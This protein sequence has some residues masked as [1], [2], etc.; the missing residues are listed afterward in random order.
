MNRSIGFRFR[1]VATLAVLACLPQSVYAEPD[2]LRLLPPE[3]FGF[4]YVQNPSEISKELED[5]GIE[6]GV[7][8]PKLLDVARSVAGIEEGFDAGKELVLG[9]SSPAQP[10]QQPQPFALVPVSDYAT[11]VASFLPPEQ[12]DSSGIKQITMGGSQL[13]CAERSGYALLV[14]AGNG[15]LIDKLLSDAPRVNPNLDAL[16]DDMPDHDV[17]LVVLQP[18]VQ[19]ALDTVI[20]SIEQV[21]A[22]LEAI[23]EDVPEQLEA[24]R[25]FISLYLDCLRVFRSDTLLVG[26]GL[27]I[28]D[29]HNTL[30]VK[31]ILLKPDGRMSR[32]FAAKASADEKPLTKLVNQP[33]VLAAALSLPKEWAAS[34]AN[35]SLRMLELSSPLYGTNELSDADR[36]KMRDAYEATMEGI[37]SIAVTVGSGQPGD[38]LYGNVQAVMRVRNASAYLTKYEEALAVL[39][40]LWQTAGGMLDVSYE[41]ER[42][43]QSNLEGLK[44][45]IGM[46]AD[47]LG[48]A[49]AEINAM[50]EKMFGPGGKMISYLLKVDDRTC[51]W[52]MV[53]ESELQ[54]A[55]EQYRNNPEGLQQPARLSQTGRMLTPD[56]AVRVYISPAG[57]VRFAQ[58]AAKELADADLP[59]PGFP[60]CPPVGLSMAWDAGY[61]EFRM[62]VPGKVFRAVG[63]FAEDMRSGAV[64][65]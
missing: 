57:V 17:A 25:A 43:A 15:P 14:D 8:L 26:A 45:T 51:L 30:F 12:A 28:D 55:V 52:V 27:S 29:Q 23:G 31:R 41:A 38:P 47:S 62:A 22:R 24:G 63:E 35:L 49:S 1:C 44:I 48:E 65:P 56:A 60:A 2:V 20:D 46:S 54:N 18:G 39:N 42:V 58:R 19:Y 59:I 37:E 16:F 34:M 61:L 6:L 33:F 3:A 21:M 64:Q 53:P 32:V 7:A 50:F 13:L 36:Q 5:I 11:F 10:G 9:A 40:Q 4:V